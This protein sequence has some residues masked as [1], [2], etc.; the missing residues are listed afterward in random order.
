VEPSSAGGFGFSDA[1]AIL[2]LV[3]K[4]YSFLGIFWS[5]FLFKNAFKWLNKC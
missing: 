5:K 3:F 1:A 2:Q 4:K